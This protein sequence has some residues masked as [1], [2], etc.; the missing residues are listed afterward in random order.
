MFL[1]TDL[2]EGRLQIPDVD[3][4]PTD[5]FGGSVATTSV[6]PATGEGTREEQ[7]TAVLAAFD[8]WLEKNA[9]PAAN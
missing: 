5:A 7:V 2:R 6:D 8:E 1:L 4:D 9:N 3:Q